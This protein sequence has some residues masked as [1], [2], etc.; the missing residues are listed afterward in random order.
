MG[1]K[2]MA[3]NSEMTEKVNSDLI[4]HN[5]PDRSRLDRTSTPKLVSGSQFIPADNKNNFKAV[6]GLIIGLGI[7]LVGALIYFSYRFIIKSQT[8][9]QAP[10]NQQTET[11]NLNPKVEANIATTTENISTS[12]EV[13]VKE[14]NTNIIDLT[15][16]ENAST[17]TS[18]IITSPTSSDFIDEG[19]AFTA[20][21]ILDSDSDGLNDSEEKVLGTNPNLDDSDGDGYSDLS[22]LKNGYNPVSASQAL[23][24]NDFLTSYQSKVG[25][26]QIYYPTS[27]SIK[28]INNDYTTI[29][30]TPD[31]SLLQISVQDNVNIQSIMSWYETTFPGETVTYDRLK[32]GD[33]WEGI[34][35]TDGLNF[36]ITDSKRENI[37]VI[38]YIPSISGRLVYP[39]IF[40]LIINS[41]KTN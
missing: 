29:I 22:E 19:Q 16:E 8:V 37:Y 30:S 41:F 24:P 6:G 39:E 13:E 27:W 17:T 5:M 7:I 32:N 38:S 2:K 23:Y 21:P 14:D 4:V 18:E 10:I 11:E 1:N 35:G 9:P 40:Q 25:K 12:T 31:N 15:G 28:S 34:F 26:Y 33:A 20:S 36:Y 3:V